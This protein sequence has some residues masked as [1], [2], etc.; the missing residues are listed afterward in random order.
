MPKSE[1]IEQLKKELTVHESL[2]SFN[3]PIGNLQL[4]DRNPRVGSVE[5][6][7]KSLETNGQYKPIVVNKRTGKILAGNHTYKA[8]V[9]LGWE[10]IAVSYVDVDEESA[11]RIVLADNRT[12]DF[13]T[14]D[15]TALAEL[16]KSLPSLEGTGFAEKDLLR[17]EAEL[18]SGITKEEEAGANDISKVESRCE[19]GQI[20]QLGNH[21]LACGDATEAH[22]VNALLG[23]A[24]IELMVT[25][26]PYGVEVD[27]TWR[28]TRLKR[29]AGTARTGKV[30]NDDRA[31]WSAAYALSPAP[32]AYIWHAGTRAKEVWDSITEVG[33]E[34]RQQII[35]VKPNFVIGRANYHWQHEPC[36]Y[37]VRKGCSASF[38]GGRKQTTVWETASPI[39]VQATGDEKTLHPTQKPLELYERPIRNHVSDDGAIYEPFC[40]SGTAIIAAENTGRKCYAIELD[41]QYCEVAI[42]RWERLTGK[43]AELVTDSEG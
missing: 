18:L 10:E 16:L 6:I 5:A 14:Y 32:V 25:D 8:A 26:P 13:A 4:Y 19:P 42:S 15:D 23:H 24:N 30:L 41:P 21:R 20:W 28:E 40:G 29:T 34:I 37:A 33:L 12:S 43:T 17:L 35:W 1:Q 31:D 2:K 22:T 9:E 39:S 3:V 27:H 36:Y 11:A 38:S 7:K